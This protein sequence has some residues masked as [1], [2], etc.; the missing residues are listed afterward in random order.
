MNTICE[1]G[2]CYKEIKIRWYVGVMAG[3]SAFNVHKPEKTEQRS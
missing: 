2:N 3:K 1:S